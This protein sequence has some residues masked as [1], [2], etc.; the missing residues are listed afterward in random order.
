MAD[1]NEAL[2]IS[3]QDIVDLIS[4]KEAVPA[5]ESGLRLEH[6]GKAQNMKKTHAVWNDKKSTL[7]ALGAVFDGAGLVG[8]KTWSHTP[9]GACPLLIL[10]NSDNGKLLAVLEAFALGQMRTAAISGV[11]TRYMSSPNANDMAII[12]TGKQ[13]LA[14]V[15]GVNAVRDLQ[16]LR[17]YSPTETKRIAFAEKV[18]A[19]FNFDVEVCKN[20]EST[21]KDADIVTL[22]TRSQESILSADML[23]NGCHLNAVGA[24]TPERKEFSQ[25]IFTRTRLIAVDTVDS[26]RR[27]SSE[28][29]E[30]FGED[31][32]NWESVK[33][34]SSLVS[35]GTTRPADCEIS[36][37]KAMG[38]GLSDLSM[39]SEIL[40][41]ARENGAGRSIPQPEKKPLN[42]N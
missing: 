23:T 39:G 36:L 17:V 15:A 16:R 12:G 5:L 34:L 33:P 32:A 3:E 20:V 25:D 13:A 22:V 2:W 9:G 4:L 29:I 41:R 27:L 10:F 14:Q 24:I 18:R 38:M 11:A 6:E 31:D 7:H 37:F 28:F 26:V 19:N 35:S 42:Y 21:V 8:T 40:K 30:Q 1:T